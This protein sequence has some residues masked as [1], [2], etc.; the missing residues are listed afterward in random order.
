MNR[1]P[2]RS[3]ANWCIFELE[4]KRYSLAPALFA[5]AFESFAIAVR[6]DDSI[7]R[8]SVGRSWIKNLLYADDTALGITKLETKQSNS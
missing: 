1:S 6:Q 2:Q 3:K 4:T 8:Y 5:F 7:K